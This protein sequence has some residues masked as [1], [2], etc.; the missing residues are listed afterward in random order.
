MHQKQQIL[1]GGGGGVVWSVPPPAATAVSIKLRNDSWFKISTSQ[2][3][4]LSAQEKCALVTG[5]AVKVFILNGGRSEAGHFRVRL[6]E[7]LTGCE[8]AKVGQTGFVFQS[9]VD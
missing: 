8:F 9:H 2:S 7:S 4:E 6:A 3:T 5:Q 1:R